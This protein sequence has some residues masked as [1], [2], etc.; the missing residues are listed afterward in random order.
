MFLVGWLLGLLRKPKLRLLEMNLQSA[1]H[2]HAS[3]WVAFRG[4][5]LKHTNGGHQCWG[6]ITGGY[7]IPTRRETRLEREKE[8]GKENDANSCST[9]PPPQ[10][11]ARANQ[12]IGEVK[13]LITMP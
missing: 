3:F 1:A 12:L 13:G 2:L 8:S 10:W 9:L 5:S 4:C 7:R 6:S 11:G